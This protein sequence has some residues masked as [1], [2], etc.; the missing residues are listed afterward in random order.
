MDSTLKINPSTL[1]FDLP[2]DLIAQEPLAE[3]DK[4]RLMVV[5]RKNDELLHKRFADLTE[6]LV[7]GDVLVLNRARV[8]TAKFWARKPTGGRV[9]VIFIKEA[10][11]PGVWKTLLRP[12]QKEGVVLQFEGG[13]AATLIGRTEFGENLLKCDNFSPADL[14]VSKGVVPLPPYIR[15]DENDPRL[16]T[17]NDDYQTV[18]ASVPGSIAA[19]TAGLHFTEE[20]L[21]RLRVQGVIIKEIVL[22]V[23]WG[24]FRP[25]AGG[26]E[27]HKML[28]ESFE[29]PPLV[30]QELQ[31]AKKENRRIVAVGTTVTR[32][33][34]SLSLREPGPFYR[35]N[36]S[37]FITPGY[38]FKWVSA[39]ITNLHVPRSTPVA[40][41][42][43][44]GGLSKLEQAY[45]EAV[46]QKY[47]FFSY[48]DA[49]LI[50]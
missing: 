34:E 43:A 23:G 12:F 44:F 19:P 7:P 11:E 40:L 48:G 27:A 13:A 18:Y 28:E 36:T 22:S 24:T 21:D 45:G 6:F 2:D 46:K 29:V 16:K 20:L 31:R 30:Y 33:L 32:A 4:A 5:N 1:E 41:T 25:I 26:V 3:R 49:M 47:R 17:D 10:D 39:L 9:E 15:R 38:A 42:A 8:N 50:I 35:G 37:L 14:M